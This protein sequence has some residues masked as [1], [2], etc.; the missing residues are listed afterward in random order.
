V[1]V[2]VEDRRGSVL[3]QAFRDGLPLGD[4]AAWAAGAFPPG[5][6]RVGPARTDPAAVAGA[7]GRRLGGP[8]PR[9]APLYLRPADAAPPAEAPPR[10]L[11]DAR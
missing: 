9:P 8:V 10:I 5:A 11:D 2:L 6:R 3:A 7:A 1:V 4:P